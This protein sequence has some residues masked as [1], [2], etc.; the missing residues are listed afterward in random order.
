MIYSSTIAHRY[1]SDLNFRK[2]VLALHNQGFQE[3]F[4]HKIDDDLDDPRVLEAI[5]IIISG[6]DGPVYCF[7]KTA[8]QICDKINPK[9]DNK[10]TYLD[11]LSDGSHIFVVSQ[12]EFIRVHKSGA[13]VVVFSA[14]RHYDE[15]KKE[16]LKYCM[17]NFT[18]DEQFE[19][20]IEEEYPMKTRKLLFQILIFMLFTEKEIIMLDAGRKSGTRAEGKVVNDS[21]DKIIIVDSAWNKIL[22]RG[23]GFDVSGHLR[24][25]SCGPGRMNLELVWVNPYKKSGYT[26]KSPTAI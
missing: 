11:R 14:L 22:V 13:R 15:Q 9:T 1:F 3:R 21:K 7:R 2:Q 12:D 6:K 23:E 26:R 24:L 25:Q 16:K 8:L 10:F 19:G 5:N 18:I 17:F 20:I 4:N